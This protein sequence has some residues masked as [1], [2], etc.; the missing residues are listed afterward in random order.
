VT[1]EHI[2]IFT[3]GLATAGL[4]GVPIIRAVWN[5][6]VRLTYHKIKA[7]S[8]FTHMEIEAQMSAE[9]ARNAA[10]IRKL[11]RDLAQTRQAETTLRIEIGR[12]QS[13]YSAA[14]AE[15]NAA[16]ETIQ[17]LENS[18]A[19]LNGRMI[20]KEEHLARL[21]SELREADRKLNDARAAYDAL[22]LET[23]DAMA[24]ADVLRMN[25]LAHQYS[26]EDKAHTNQHKKL[27]PAA[28]S[29]TYAEEQSQAQKLMLDVIDT[30]KS[31]LNETEAERDEAIRQKDN[32][33]AEAR[34]YAMIYETSSGKSRIAQLETEKRTLEEQVQNLHKKLHIESEKSSQGDLLKAIENL[35]IEVTA[36]E[37]AN[38]NEEHKINQALEKA[39]PKGLA[40]RIRQARDR[41]THNA[42]GNDRA[43]KRPAMPDALEKMM[44][45]ASVQ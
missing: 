6:A 7:N 39:P 13:S 5:R 24:T 8:P 9:R 3:L 35:A 30:L 33:E 12:L 21:R 10:A 27:V 16:A 20:A 22:Q 4:L 25:K 36:R 40:I 43:S 19:S 26:A 42:P 44:Q 28:Q 15:R 2:L 38:A 41:M 23:A 45:D 17:E 14:N 18:V 34:H 1:L 11:E 37:A 31:K 32:A 29:A